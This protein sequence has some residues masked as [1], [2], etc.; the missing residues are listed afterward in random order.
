MK[1]KGSERGK[2]TRAVQQS[3]SFLLNVITK[4]LHTFNSDYYSHKKL[5]EVFVRFAYNKINYHILLNV[6]H[7]S[8]R[9]V[10]IVKTEICPQ[11][12]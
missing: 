5:S 7:L 11:I 6:T 1:H 2:G 10:M 8:K 9:I 12:P 4:T 3:L